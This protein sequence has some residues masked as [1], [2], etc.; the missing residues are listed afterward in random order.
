RVLSGTV[1]DSAAGIPLGGAVV[2]LVRLDRADA[3]V[4]SSATLANDRGRY[5]IAGVAPGHYLIGF[6]HEALRAFRIE[7]PA[8]RVDVPASTT[9]ADSNVVVDLAMPSAA[10]LRASLCGPNEQVGGLIAGRVEDG[11]TGAP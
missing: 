5:R 7:A 10:D 9:A 3:P 4:S 1:F 6:Q 8:R 11:R 2:Q